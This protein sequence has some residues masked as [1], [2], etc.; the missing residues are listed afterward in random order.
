MKVVFLDQDVKPDSASCGFKFVARHM[1]LENALLSFPVH[2]GE[3]R[4][5]YRFHQWFSNPEIWNDPYEKYFINN[6]FG[7]EDCPIKDHVAVACYT[8][9]RV[10]EA[11]WT[12]YSQKEIAIQVGLRWAGL[13]DCLRKHKD[14]SLVAYVGKVRYLGTDKIKKKKFSSILDVTDKDL[15][16]MNARDGNELSARLLTIKRP[17]YSYEE[18]IRIIIVSSKQIEKGLDI[19]P[20]NKK[21][22]DRITISPL[23]GTETT[24][25]L[26]QVFERRGGCHVYHSTLYDP[27]T[28]DVIE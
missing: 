3:N 22:I 2:K 27:V 5:T 18:E 13:I 21:I 16:Q 9:N 7:D 26:K 24:A 8:T 4:S 12:V 28:N 15:K 6:S 25:L 17:A 10:S 20:L 1:A 19:G 11:Q 14:D 23:A